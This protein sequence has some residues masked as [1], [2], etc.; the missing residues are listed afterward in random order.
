MQVEQEKTL[1]E[2]SSRLSWRR[3]CWSPWSTWSP[4]NS[5]CGSGLQ[6]RTRRRTYRF[7]WWRCQDGSEA[8]RCQDGSFERRRCTGSCPGPSSTGSVLA[9]GRAI[10]PYSQS[11][12]MQ[13]SRASFD[14][15]TCLRRV[16]PFSGR[17]HTYSHHRT[18]RNW[19]LDRCR[20]LFQTANG[21]SSTTGL[22]NNLPPFLAKLQVST[23]C[24]LGYPT[25]SVT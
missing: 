15:V 4:C 9:H 10:Y 17:R 19:R 6:H 25:Y 21:P 5:Q 1:V 2:A 22:R 12:N 18:D 8:G 3:C 24:F 20:R 14:Y 7:F 13:Q 11:I 16:K 23:L